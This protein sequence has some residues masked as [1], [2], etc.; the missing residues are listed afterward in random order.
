VTEGVSSLPRA[1]AE[2]RANGRF[3]LIVIAALVGLGAYWLA[4]FAGVPSSTL[5]LVFTL[6]LPVLP[7]LVLWA[8]WRAPPSLR[9]FT[10]LAAAAASFQ[11]V[12]SVLWYMAFLRN[13]S[14]VPEPPGFWTPFLHVALAFGAAAAWAGVRSVIRLRQAALDYSIVFAAAACVAAVAVG[15]QLETGFEPAS[16]DAVVRPVLN[17]AMVTIVASA[18]LGRWQ[19]LPLPV[20]L[21]GLAQLFSASG[22]LLFGFLTAQGAYS[23]DRWTGLLW[24]TG[25]VIGMVGASAV[26]LGVVRPVRMA[27]EPLPVISPKALLIAAVAASAIAATA[28]LYGALAD[29]RAALIAGVLASLWI[30]VAV[31]LRTLAAVQEARAAYR[32]LDEAHRELERVSDQ[33]A[34][35]VHEHAMTIDTLARRNAEL[36]AVH[37]MLGAL[38]EEVDERTQGE[39]RA[40]LEEVG[41]DLAAWVPEPGSDDSSSS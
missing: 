4:T 16:L 8:A 17:V 11:A 25:A 14:E 28:T 22:D 26:I 32:R 39:L 38:L 13:G 15:E 35:L 29:H 27:R 40:R 37:V 10:R 12:G 5:S 31:P 41:D 18:A 1:A 30:G 33:T 34:D 3:R 9:L 6:A 23:D 7:P 24:L 2:A 20:A 19:G 21:L 36:S